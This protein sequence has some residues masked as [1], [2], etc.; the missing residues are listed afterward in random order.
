MT[1]FYVN[2]QPKDGGEHRTLLADVEQVVIPPAGMR[3]VVYE[4]VSV[5]ILHV[6]VHPTMDPMIHV[7]GRTLFPATTAE[8]NEIVAD[9]VN[10]E[11]WQVLGGT[12]PRKRR[13]A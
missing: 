2:I 7:C 9:A 1:R 5:E 12:A 8:A 13:K 10:L 6:H 11:G 4:S 3:L